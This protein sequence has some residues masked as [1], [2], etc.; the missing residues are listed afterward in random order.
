MPRR[1]LPARMR[2][3]AALLVLLFLVAAFPPPVATAAAETPASYGFSEVDSFFSG[4]PVTLREIAWHPSGRYALIAGGLRGPSTDPTAG[5][6]LLL[7]YDNETGAVTPVMNAS[8]KPMLFAV[9][10]A[11]DGTHALVVGEKDAVFR[12]DDATGAVKDLWTELQTT[13]LASNPG[14]KPPTFL[15]RGM[16]YRPDGKYAL[17]T[18]SGLLAYS[19]KLD[20]HFAVIDPGEMKY[21]KAVAFAPDSSYAI[22]EGGDTYPENDPQ[23]RGG[24]ARIGQLWF[25][26]TTKERCERYYVDGRAW[27]MAKFAI[28]YGYFDPNRADAADITFHPIINASFVYGY[29]DKYGSILRIRDNGTAPEVKQPTADY[30]PEWMVAN[31]QAGK[32]TDMEFR[33]GGTRALVTAF[34]APQIVEFDGLSVR[35]VLNDEICDDAFGKKCPSLE[36]VAWHPT[37]SYALTV[38]LY[39]SIIK[40]SPTPL[41]ELQITTPTESQTIVDKGATSLGV[42]GTAYATAF[43]SKIKSVKIAVDG[44]EWAEANVT[45]RFNPTNWRYRWNVSSVLPGP[46]VLSV[47]AEDTQGHVSHTVNLTVYVALPPPPLEKPAWSVENSTSRKGDFVLTW[48]PVPGALSY[49]VQDSR[50]P[51]FAVKVT[52]PVE[53]G[54]TPS[55][56]S[57]S[58]DNGTFYFRVMAQGA[59]RPDSPWSDTI[60]VNV[61]E[62]RRVPTGLDCDVAEPPPACT[63][64]VECDDPPCGPL[65]LPPANGTDGNTTPPPPPKNDTGGNTTPPKGTGS[66]TPGPGVLLAIA[67][68]AGAVL[69]RR[70]VR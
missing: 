24:Q 44:G 30:V 9:K 32:Y 62:G 64:P 50:D 31:H 46:H 56:E 61:T 6:Q 1:P 2:I 54:D 28:P 51:Q 36:S 14:E 29:D 11:P 67:A 43:G 53:A 52:W 3:G 41:P 49:V 4:T 27:C 68:L 17:L 23:G 69:A 47:F 34:G 26:G 58:R 21:F 70:R 8:G 65:V 12:Y 48:A 59:P 16:T 37:S 35:P 10:F 38:G 63:V 22:V 45:G 66:G 39:G 57:L 40:I 15:G 25:M 33:P 13:F 55:F 7:R 42:A 5:Y 20:P 19:D 18:G 60:T